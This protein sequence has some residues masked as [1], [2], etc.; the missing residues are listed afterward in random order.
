MII[1]YTMK[2]LFSY[3]MGGHL[4]ALTGV[5]ALH[6]GIVAWAMA[7]QPPLAI[8]QQQ[9]IQI[10]MVAPTVIQQKQAPE[11]AQEAKKIPKTPPKEMGMVKVE[12]KPR[13]MPK[14][15]PK[16]EKTEQS[17]EVVEQRT[18][19]TSGLQS[20]QAKETKAAITEPVAAAYLKNPAPEYP[21]RARSRRQQ[22]T[23]MLEVRVTPAG[24][25]KVVEISRS[26][27]YRLLDVAALDA[28]KQWR[29]VPARRGSERVEASVVVPVEFRIN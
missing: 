14:A 25:P 5:T 19:L 23:V 27:G 24:S 15:E 18:Q 8:P 29:F 12:P 11:P 21:S 1:N 22:G 17:K 7:P 6:A 13:P 10:S 2:H 26:S 20:Q 28:V 9:V 4:L 16:L 3:D